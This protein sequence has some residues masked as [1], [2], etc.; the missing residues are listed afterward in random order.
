MEE[1]Q[2]EVNLKTRVRGYISYVHEKQKK[3]EEIEL[4]KIFNKLSHS[5]KNELLIQAHEKILSSIPCL[6]DNF[7]DEFLEKL[8]FFI[9]EKKVAPEESIYNV[10]SKNK[11]YHEF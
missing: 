11:L 8:T 1:K 10:I 2:I 5:L 4:K 6:A 9:K 7:S 3:E